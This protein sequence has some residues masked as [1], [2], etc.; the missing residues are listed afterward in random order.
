MDRLC[1]I[2]NSPCYKFKE[3]GSIFL[4]KAYPA[5][6]SQE[7]LQKLAIE[8]KEYFDATHHCY[9]FRLHDGKTKSSDNGEPSGTAG[10]KILSAI[11]QKDIQ[12][13]VIIVTRYFGGVKLGT[14]PLGKAYFTAAAGA[15]ECAEI[16]EKEPYL[17]VR[18]SCGYD[19]LSP[20]ERTLGRFSATI[21]SRNFN[22]NPDIRALIRLSVQAAFL[23]EI[24][25]KCLGRVKV[26]FSEE[27]AWL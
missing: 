19:V 11:M 23:F 2:K 6:S 14:G 12:D 13:I 1:T 26:S 8:K 3:K 25:A 18:V 17:E 22:P 4:A 10:I 5:L 24:E 27:T 16:I 20:V 7:A 15:L 9:A 21:K